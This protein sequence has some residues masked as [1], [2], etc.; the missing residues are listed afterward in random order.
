VGELLRTRVARYALAVGKRLLLWGLRTF[1]PLCRFK[2]R[3]V[4]TRYADVRQVLSLPNFYSVRQYGS[5]MRETGPDFF[6]GHD[7]GAQ[8]VAE[9]GAACGAIQALGTAAVRRIAQQDALDAIAKRCSPGGAEPFYLDVVEDLGDRVPV[10]VAE[11][12]F[13]L[14]NPGQRNLLNWIQLT[15]WY[16][17]NPF[18]SDAARERAIR[19]GDELKEHVTRLVRA[20]RAAPGQQT[21]LGHLLAAGLGDDEAARTLTGLVAGSLGPPPRFFAKAVNRLLRLRG[22][23]RAKLVEAA[24]RGG[25]EGREE[26]FETLEKYLLEAGRFDPD[27]SLLY[28]ACEATTPTVYGGFIDAGDTIV[29]SIESALR[30]WRSISMPWRFR[31]DRPEHERM[32]FGHGLHECIGRGVGIATLTGMLQPLFALPGL[33]RAPGSAGTLRD[34][35]L[36][37]FP[38]QDYPR[39]LGVYFDGP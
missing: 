27:P 39:H 35:P 29:C 12:Y 10:R 26:D 30:D 18:A 31:L 13:G 25:K 3:V 38:A 24:Q 8:R 20:A 36:G 21:V 23:K 22:S 4:V 34:G 14:P 2:G 28:R 6:L 7:R 33:R 5:R 37:K 19:A 9:R 15:S 11:E 1:C 16:I 32:L 17:F